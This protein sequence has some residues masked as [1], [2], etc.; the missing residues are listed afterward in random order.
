MAASPL[1]SIVIP[2]LNAARLLPRCLDS[3]AAQTF[4]DFEVLAVDGASTDGTME[5]FRLKGAN[6]SFLVSEP[7]KGV[8][9]ARNKALAHV[10][11]EWICFLGAD[12]WLWDANAL[13]A[14]APQ[15]RTAAPRYRVVY[16]RLR[17]VDPQGRVV[18]EMGDTWERSKA[19]FFSYGLIPHP[20]LMH[21]RT[22]FDAHGPF[23]E[24]FTVSGDVELLLRE[25][26]TADALFVPALTVGMEFGGFS[27]KPENYR[28]VM[29]ETGEALRR[30]G[31]APPR[32]LWAYWTFCAWAYV[33]LRALIGDR[34]AR[35]LADAYRVLTLRKPR[36]SGHRD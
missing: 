23:D 3:I 13:A 1:I 17:M 35:L 19:G 9:A 15:L 11:G 31:F 18:E 33:K 22:L 24:R 4:R 27:T 25:L 21:H 36:F 14:L 32:L 2:T 6:I 26:K 29:Q 5:I 16:S 8:Y 12:D 34:N 30:H 7:D 20:G 28:R 10:K